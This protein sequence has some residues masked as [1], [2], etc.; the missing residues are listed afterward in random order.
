MAIY[1]IYMRRFATT[2][3]REG[4]KKDVGVTV[5][6]SK[7]SCL[8]TVLVVGGEGNG[9][10]S[11]SVTRRLSFSGPDIDITVGGLGTDGCV[12]VSRG[13]FVGLA[14]AKRRVTSGV[15]RERAFLAK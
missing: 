5:R 14:R 10:H 3:S 15:C 6:R 7:R 2:V 4:G 11:V 9:I 1:A 8:R 13:K 12:A